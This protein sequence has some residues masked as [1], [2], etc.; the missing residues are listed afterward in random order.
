MIPPVY[1]PRQQECY[2]TVR[3]GVDQWLLSGPGELKGKRLGLVTS[4][5]ATCAFNA[6]TSRVALRRAGFNLVRLFSPEHGLAATAPDGALVNDEIDPATNL[7]VVSLYGNDVR[8]RPE[9]LHDLDAIVYDIPDVGARFY[10][11]IWTLSHVMEACAEAQK[12]IYILDRPNP[13]GGR[14]EDAEGP[15]LDEQNLSSFVG[16][17]N[18]PIRYALTIGE[19]ARLWNAERK[20]AA[21][22]HVVKVQG[23]RR[24]MHWPQTNLNFTKLSP[25]MPSYETA[26]VYPGTCLFEGT[27]LSEGRG[28]DA[29]F[30]LI[31]AP[32]I[33]GHRL[34]DSFNAIALPGVQTRAQQFVP[35][36]RKYEGEKCAGIKFEVTDTKTFRPVKSALH[37]I[38]RII[39]LY[40]NEFDWLPYPTAAAAKGLQHFDR[41]LGQLN[42]RQQLEENPRDLPE[43]IENWTSPGPWHDR[44]KPHLLYDL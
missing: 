44:V 6:E 15:E 1:H 32:W 18:I 3:F 38:A 34:S 8:P 2:V 12:P 41:L 31:G 17:W 33:D 13:L 30:R 35:D 19:L 42:V 23:W 24:E 9:T 39:E 4:N 26:L 7:S 5:V 36:E 14:L 37:L 20:I 10:T 21:D 29:P 25:A 16:R 28:T 43:R 40:P 11:Y 22:L 27:N